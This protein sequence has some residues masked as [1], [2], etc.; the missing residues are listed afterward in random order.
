MLTKIM[1]WASIAVLLL[2]GLRL[3]KSYQGLWEMVVCV[4]ALL[5]VAQAVR[6]A[7]YFWAAGF[8]AIVVLFNPVAP[9]VLSAK[10]LLW[11]N[12]VCLAAFLVSLAVLKRSPTLSI[13]SITN[14]TPRSES[15]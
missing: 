10:I 13:P 3:A 14:R 1:K 15:L 8:L 9:I 7:K 12:W 6:A 4:S 5:V 11:L 2:V